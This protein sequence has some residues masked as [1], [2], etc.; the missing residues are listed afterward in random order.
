MNPPRKLIGLT[1]GRLKVLEQ[2][3][4]NKYGQSMWHCEC[5]CGKKTV[6][7]GGNLT[8]RKINSCGCIRR[9]ASSRVRPSTS[10]QLQDQLH[11]DRSQVLKEKY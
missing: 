11:E 7:R 10:D 5:S 4:S 1:F 3:P 9:K 2:A 6:V 8:M